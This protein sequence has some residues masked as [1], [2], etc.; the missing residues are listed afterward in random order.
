MMTIPGQRDT[1][2]AVPVGGKQLKNALREV[3][4]PKPLPFIAHPLALDF[5]RLLQSGQKILKLDLMKKVQPKRRTKFSQQLIGDR[6]AFGR[7]DDRQ[8]ESR[9]KV[10]W[11]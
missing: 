5:L 10:S 7:N 9:V 11:H 4:P 2:A 1:E 8:K 3:M 6:A